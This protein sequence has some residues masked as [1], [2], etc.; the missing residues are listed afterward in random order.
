MYVLSYTQNPR[1]PWYVSRVSLLT[2]TVTWC[3]RKHP[4]KREKQSTHCSSWCW[5]E[6]TKQNNNIII[7]KNLAHYIIRTDLVLNVRY[8]I[9]RLKNRRYTLHQW[10][11]YYW[12][13]I[14]VADSFSLFWLIHWHLI[15]FCCFYL[16][17]F[18][19]KSFDMMVVLYNFP[20]DLLLK[21]R[22]HTISICKIL[23]TK[24]GSC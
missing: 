21:W 2:T 3:L 22:K 20:P 6:K 19:F 11:H 15:E 7:Q 12:L 24:W 14:T 10:D 8:W 9:T 4:R 13:F 23:K 18:Y 5:N 17:L 1:R 16:L